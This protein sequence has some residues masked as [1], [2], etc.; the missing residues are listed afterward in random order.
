M[1]SGGAGIS[2]KTN[3]TRVT[4][5]LA[6]EASK[7]AA[8]FS[9]LQLSLSRH[10]LP[11]PLMSHFPPPQNC[12]LATGAKTGEKPRTTAVSVENQTRLFVHR[13]N[14]NHLPLWI[15]KFQK[16]LLPLS[17]TRPCSRDMP[18]TQGRTACSISVI[19]VDLKGQVVPQKM[20]C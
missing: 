18:L 16:P 19:V 10:C 15:S 17:E 13:W 6:S 4:C 20:C 3:D 1:T 2:R 8:T 9:A 7:A 5:S 14:V 12:P 11:T